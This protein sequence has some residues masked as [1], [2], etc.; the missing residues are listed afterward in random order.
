MLPS[1]TAHEEGRPFADRIKASSRSLLGLKD[2]TLYDLDGMWGAIRV[3][4]KR[5][6]ATTVEAIPAYTKDA[7]TLY[8]KDE[9]GDELAHIALP[10]DTMR[11]LLDTHSAPFAREDHH[12]QAELVKRG[13]RTWMQQANVTLPEP[14]LHAMFL[15]LECNAA[16]ASP[17]R[18]DNAISR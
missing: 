15:G 10:L 13:M 12:H 3:G 18:M 6:E 1:R 8:F 4:S 14:L 5:F 2:F 7:Y 17:V 9:M 11:P 16:N